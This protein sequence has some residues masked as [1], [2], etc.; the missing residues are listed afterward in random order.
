MS[1]GDNLAAGWY[2]NPA[3]GRE[4]YWNGNAWLGIPKPANSEL[5]QT[6][7]FQPQ[8]ST[9][10][11][12]ALICAFI[13]PVVGFILGF[14]ARKEIDNSNGKK[15]GRGMATA[16]IWLGGVGT[17]GMIIIIIL[18]AIGGSGESS[19]L[20]TDATSV[21]NSTNLPEGCDPGIAQI[22]GYVKGSRCN[23]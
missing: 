7:A 22:Y 2:L 19:T 11:I 18:I 1:E 4:D 10:S 16:S 13:I 23:P 21:S 6:I 15:T 17:I 5:P 20:N 14:S 12:V 8:T 3:L 9:L